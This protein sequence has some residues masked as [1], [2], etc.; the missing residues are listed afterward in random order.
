MFGY[1]LEETDRSPGVRQ[2]G[3]ACQVGPFGRITILVASVSALAASAPNRE[4][5]AE[6]RERQRNQDGL[7]T[8]GTGG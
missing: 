3:D 7:E 4:P 2:P 6:R 5:D 1:A 8:P